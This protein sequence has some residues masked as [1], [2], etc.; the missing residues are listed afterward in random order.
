MT[1]N[2]DAE[3]EEETRVDRA[4]S[5]ARLV[6]AGHEQGAVRRIVLWVLLFGFIGG[7]TVFPVLVLPAIIVAL[8]LALT[9]Q[10]A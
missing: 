9:D 7:T 3:A 1:R 8:L 6:I 2:P 5:V 10:L 4:A